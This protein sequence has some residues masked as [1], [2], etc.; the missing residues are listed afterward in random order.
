MIFPAGG[1]LIYFRVS[2]VII[3]WTLVTELRTDIVIV[4]DIFY[5]RDFLEIPKRFPLRFDSFETNW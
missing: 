4:K 1:A 5:E 3:T 2:N